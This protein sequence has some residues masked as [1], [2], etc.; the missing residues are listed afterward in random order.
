MPAPFE[1]RRRLVINANPSSNLVAASIYGNA[2]S[3]V[4][5]FVLSTA[6]PA[7][8][9]T[10]E[11]VMK[12]RRAAL[13]DLG[14]VANGFVTGEIGANRAMQ[15]RYLV[16][17]NSPM[18]VNALRDHLLAGMA[19][20]ER[21]EAVGWFPLAGVENDEFH[22]FVTTLMREQPSGADQV[23]TLVAAVPGSRYA[24]SP[25]IEAT[26]GELTAPGA[27]SSS[28]SSAGRARCRSFWA[29]PYPRADFYWVLD[30]A[31]SM[32]TYHQR[33]QASARHFANRL[34]ASELDFRFGVTSMIRAERGRLRAAA[35]WH[36]DLA[37]L[38]QEIA[39]VSERDDN[40]ESMLTQ[41]G[42]KVAREGIIFMRNLTEQFNP[43]AM[44]IRP[45][46]ELFTIFVSQEPPHSVY[47]LSGGE[48]DRQLN[49]YSSFFERESRVVSIVGDETCSP[50][51][52]AA[53]R[54]VA[55]E[56]TGATSAVCVE[57]MTATL[58]N[59]AEYAAL[60]SSKYK[61]D[62]D[63]IPSSIQVFIEGQPVPQ[64]RTD[65]FDYSPATDSIA[66]FGS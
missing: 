44:A 60:T 30:Q 17:T 49:Y 61:L 46:T 5:G 15:A 9:S 45:D 52:P 54:E 57:N 43:G 64:S 3:D 41:Y 59:V 19:P 29:K 14:E 27:I 7:E 62:D 34:L 16:R 13:A 65:G 42:L 18:T 1:N 12:T 28:T 55:Y 53:Y 23:L 26:L 33:L 39:A 10:P 63:V 37:T 21:N 31:P 4:A 32:H 56:S 20:F 47:Q 6:A 51:D 25:E 48:R 50:I 40:S 58:E 2:R 22:V 66:F 35:G 8:A 36:S 24:A 11:E 38:R